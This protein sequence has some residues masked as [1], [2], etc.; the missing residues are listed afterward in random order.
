MR[1]CVTTSWKDIVDHVDEHL[2]PFPT[3][4]HAP[5]PTPLPLQL[6]FL[7][8]FDCANNNEIHMKIA[9]TITATITTTS[10]SLCL[11]PCSSPS[12]IIFSAIRKGI[13]PL[14]IEARDSG[15]LYNR[16]VHRSHRHRGRIRR[17]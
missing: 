5:A 4:T 1:E 3:P 11:F 9:R 2:I 16:L 14:S 13:V 17:W 6:I 10:C 15:N 7:L 12:C 8:F